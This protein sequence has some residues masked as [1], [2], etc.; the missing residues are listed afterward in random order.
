VDDWLHDAHIK[1]F[2]LCSQIFQHFFLGFVVAGKHGQ[3]E[4]YC[5]DDCGSGASPQ[6]S[7]SILFGYP[8]EGIEDILVVSSVSHCQLAIGLHANQCEI[9][10][11]G[12]EC[13]YESGDAGTVSFLEE[14]EGLW[15]C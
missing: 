1:S 14:G 2:L 11:V 4:H 7:N 6:A 12:E 3:V 5:S 15:I 8:A 9:C 10:G 13:A